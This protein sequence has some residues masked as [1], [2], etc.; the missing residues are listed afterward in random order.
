M[1]RRNSETLRERRRKRV[2][3][4][5]EI[6]AADD[7]LSRGY[8]F[9]GSLV[10]VLALA[11]SVA[12]TLDGAEERCGALL[13]TVE[14]ATSVFFAADYALRV[15][16]ARC[17]Y[18]T[19]TPGKAVLRYV[20]SVGGLID[21][22][23]FLP[24][25]LP[26]FFPSGMVA[27]RM[28]RVVRIFRLFRINAY[29]DSLHVITE[30]LRSKRQQLLSSVFIILTLMLASSLCMYSLEHEAQPEVFQNAFSG[31]WWSVSTLL[32]VG[33]GDIYPITT[34]GKVFGIVI[35][36]LGVGMVAIPTGIISAGFVDQYSRIKRI[37]EYGQ[38][39]DVH[40]IQVYLRRKDAWVGKTVRDAG[41]PG[42][43]IAAAIQRGGRIVMPRGDTVLEA[44]DTLVLGA[45][46]FRSDQHIDLKEITLRRQNPWVGQHIRELDI[47]RRTLIVLVRRDGKALIPHG[48]LRLREGDTVVLYTQTAARPEPETEEIIEF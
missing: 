46:G 11:A 2:F 27:F 18:P 26:V 39:S 24:T 8:D 44:G 35:T 10:V 14:I 33:Y 4:I 40:F 1:E 21:L 47:S 43:V 9:F 41:L 42:G 34:A 19:L 20:T 16:T 5:V 45:Q 38:A 32:T 12:A 25:F 6:G 23:S 48:D 15:W 28:F 17:L 37:S 29:Y 13:D 31:I 3:E 30:V 36:F 7:A 22:V